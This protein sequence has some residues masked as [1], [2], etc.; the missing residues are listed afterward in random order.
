MA[1]LICDRRDI[2][3]VLYEQLD[4]ESLIR[5]A[6]FASLSKKTFDMIITEARNFA[7]KELLPVC[8]QGD[9]IGVELVDGD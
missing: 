3:F 1:Q 9:R 6:R 5:H 8:G 4:T 2:D 7:L